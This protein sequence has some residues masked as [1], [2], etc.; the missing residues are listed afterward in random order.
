MIFDGESSMVCTCA[1]KVAHIRSC[2]DPVLSLQ[3]FERALKTE[4]FHRSY[5]NARD[6]YCGP[7]VLF[8]TCVAMKFVHDD[9]ICCSEWWSLHPTAR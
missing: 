7:E 5:D 4:L 6:I 9:D 2:C 8:E 3:T 1:G